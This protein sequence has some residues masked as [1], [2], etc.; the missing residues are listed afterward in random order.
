[1]LEATDTHGG[2]SPLPQVS[3]EME[4]HILWVSLKKVTITGI[5][6]EIDIFIQFK[7]L[8]DIVVMCFSLVVFVSPI[9]FH[10]CLLRLKI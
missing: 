7:H 3:V 9:M 2:C 8:F 4:K 5:F 10:L 6:F 1:M